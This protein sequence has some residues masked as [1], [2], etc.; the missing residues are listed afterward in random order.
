MHYEADKDKAVNLPDI[1]SFYNKTKG[2]V[3]TFDQLCHTYRKKRSLAAVTNENS[4][5]GRFSYCPR[6]KDRT[7]RTQCATCK[8]LICNEHQNIICQSCLNF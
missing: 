6:S 2:G 5:S 8:T 4:K 7:S 3:D 1:I